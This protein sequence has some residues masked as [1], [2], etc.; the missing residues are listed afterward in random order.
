MRLYAI[1][2]LHLSSAANR[3]ALESLPPQPDDWLILAGDIGESPAHLV[4]ALS[5]LTPRFR[6]LLWAPGNHDLWTLP[7]DHGGPRG[8]AKYRQWV[9]ICH[10]HGV[11]TPEDPY[12]LW[13]GEGHACRLAPL[14][15]LYDYS[16]RPEH[17]SFDNAIEWAAESG[18]ICADEILL[19]P[20]P[21]PSR[22]AWCAARCAYT[23]ERLAKAGAQAPLILINHFPLRQD[24]VHLRWVPRFSLWCGTRQTED[25]HTRFP[26]EAV[27]YGH[28]HTR[29]TCYRDGVRFEEV[30]LGYTRD[31]NPEDGL[32]P[33]LREILPGPQP[34]APRT[35]R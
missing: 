32:K 12:V 31:W 5:I 22:T 28:L 25:W 34:Q 27:V 19:S 11:L 35:D 10:D 18:V 23:K 24:L 7:S 8:E 2:D 1:S 21:Y 17:I 26:V 15:L 29:G 6:Q 20:E 3:Q 9:S 14:F 30:S 13:P 33:Y 4:V 16:Y